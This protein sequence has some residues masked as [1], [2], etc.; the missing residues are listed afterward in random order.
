MNV[1]VANEPAVPPLEEVRDA[2]QPAVDADEPRVLLQVEPVPPLPE[3]ALGPVG[4]AID[5]DVGRPQ[6]RQG[7][8]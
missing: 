2:R 5:G 6:R 3:L 8:V 7:L 4:V 1:R